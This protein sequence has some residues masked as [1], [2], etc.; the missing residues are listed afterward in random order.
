MTPFY[1]L[2]LA[3]P[4][5]RGDSTAHL[6]CLINHLAGF[7]TGPCDQTAAVG[8][9]D[10][11]IGYRNTTVRFPVRITRPSQCHRTALDNALHSESR[12][13]ATRSS[14]P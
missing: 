4:S 2:R 11:D 9:L 1:R 7:R 10:A 3:S 13:T 5:S 8:G 12:P 6:T 14:G